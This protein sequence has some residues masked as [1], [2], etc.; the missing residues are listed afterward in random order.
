MLALPL[1]ASVALRIAQ[2]TS[3]CLSDGASLTPSPVMPTTSPH[4]CRYCT[5]RCLSD[6]NSS[7]RPSTADR[8]KATAG[9]T[10]TEAAADEGTAALVVAAASTCLWLSACFCSSWW[11]TWNRTCDVEGS[12]SSSSV[13]GGGTWGDTLAAAPAASAAA[14][15]AGLGGSCT[16]VVCCEW[17]LRLLPSSG[18]QWPRPACGA[19]VC[20]VWNSAGCSP[21]R[22][23]FR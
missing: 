10:T 5:I 6:G 13:K 18:L 9:A 4:D 19:A 7:A 21:L 22:T 12:A 16:A 2:P 20:A 17:L 1:A 23:L 14:P 11:S 15:S 8:S 3:A